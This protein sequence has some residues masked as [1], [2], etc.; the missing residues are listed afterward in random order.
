MLFTT[1]LSAALLEAAIIDLDGTFFVQLA[2][3]F[4]AL[5]VLRALVFKPM[6]ALFDAREAAMEGSRADARRMEREATEKANKFDEEMRR[7][8]LAAG[9][10]RDRLRGEGQKAERDLLEVVRKELQGQAADAEKRL[11]TERTRL[12]GELQTRAPELAREIARKLLGR[13]VS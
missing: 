11:A 10:E 1:L 8:R 5:V 12:R 13:E 7:V 6:I 9:E 2:I 4:T 3:F